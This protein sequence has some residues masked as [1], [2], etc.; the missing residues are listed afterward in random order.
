[1]SGTHA[2]R[3]KAPHRGAFFHQGGF[4]LIELVAV[5][6]IL[7]VLGALAVPRLVESPLADRGYA[8]QVAEALR[9]SHTIAVASGCAVRFTINQ[10]GYAAAQNAPDAANHCVLV[11]TWTTAMVRADGS[12]LAGVP[13]DGVAVAGLP[14]PPG[15]IQ[16]VF[17][18]Q[19]F[20]AA[21][22]APIAIGAQNVAV[23]PSGLVVGP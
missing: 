1:M 8:E 13:P 15:V 7:G 11:N 16:V 22:P 19:G 14:A 23:L 4:S 6:V 5:I 10:G 2:E 12:P 17:D 18:P 21:V 3:T 20:V 9:Y